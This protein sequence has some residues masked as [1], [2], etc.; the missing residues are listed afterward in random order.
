MTGR[1]RRGRIVASVVV[2]VVVPALGTM[3]V[4]GRPSAL[5][6]RE[7]PLQGT[8]F[9]E[10]RAPVE[11]SHTGVLWGSLVLHNPTAQDIVL[12]DV[13]IAR[14]ADQLEPSAGPYVW[15][16]SRVVLLGAGAVSAYQMPL[17]RTWNL[18]QKHPVAGFVIPPGDEDDSV[19]VLYEFPVPDRPSTIQ[20]ITVRYHAG[21]LSYRKTFDIAITIV[22]PADAGAIG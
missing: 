17:P 6:L 21:V 19:E 8:T 7:G 16:G 15:D 20:G 10:V 11:P 13:R 1:T 12:D 2:A 5:T 14:N 18:P 4:I 22:P 9:E 3:L